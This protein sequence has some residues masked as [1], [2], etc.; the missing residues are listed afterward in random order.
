MDPSRRAVLMRL[1]RLRFAATG[2]VSVLVLIAKAQAAEVS[3]A[4][5]VVLSTEGTVECLIAGAKSWTIA[6][7][8][9]PLHVGDQLRTGPRSRALVR[10]SNLSVLP[11]GELTT[12]E[13][14]PP[15]S[16][17]AKPVLNL[18]AGSVYF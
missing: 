7:V 6:T 14:Q 13:I 9:Q 18:K 4:A 8:G 15:R 12:Y 1:G 2:L 3:P 17:S 11:V 5:A 16:A 10:L